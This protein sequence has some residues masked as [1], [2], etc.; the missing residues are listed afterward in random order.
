M[1]AAQREMPAPRAGLS[2]AWDR[3]IGPGATPAEQALGWIGALGVSLAVLAY[4]LL[5]NPGWSLLQVIVLEVIAFDIGG[6]VVVNAT[7]AAKRWYHRP[8]QGMAQPLGFVA[9]HLHP[10]VIAW[11]FRDGAWLWAAGIYGW[12]IA[13]TVLIGLVPTAIKRPLALLLALVGILA[14]ALL[15]APL[16]G[17][18]WFVPLLGI[19]LL[20]SH[21][22]PEEPYGPVGAR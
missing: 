9:L 15:A 7:G 3:F 18:G 5:A 11:L 10:F 4:A 21:L 2:G 14:D 6:G 22:V 17:L 12:L 13:S 8:G 1:D 16:A 19:K 20:V